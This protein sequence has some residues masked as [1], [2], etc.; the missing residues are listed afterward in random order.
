MIEAKQGIGPMSPEIIEAVYRYSHFN[1]TPLMLIASKNQIDYNKGYVNNWS[2][3]DYMTFVKEMKEKYKNSNVKICRDHCGPGFN[4]IHELEDVYKTIETDIANGFDLMHI[5]FCHFKGSNEERLKESK[6]A[7]EHCLKLNPNILLE[8]GTDENIGAKFSINDL[9]TLE[10]EIDFFKSF[11]KPEFYVVQTG[12]LVREIN[13]AGAFNKDFIRKVADII[14]SKGLKIKEHNADYLT[15]EEIAER[16]GIVDAMNIAPQYGVIQTQLVLTKCL[17][18]GV[19]FEDFLNVVYNGGKW[20]KWLEKNTAE[21]KLLCCTI[22]GHYHFA[23][24]EYKQIIEQLEKYEDIKENIISNMM[25][26]IDHYEK[27][28]SS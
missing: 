26:V 13:Q 20:K 8:I 12:S 1:R 5:D 18:Y 23:S 25:E 14:H 24:P 4:G 15:G 7:V 6:K 10:E 17:K 19:R 2:T 27:F 3:K 16:K 22:A 9:S 11:C 28:K 21:N